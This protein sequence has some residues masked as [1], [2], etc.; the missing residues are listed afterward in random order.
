MDASRVAVLIPGL[1]Y[2]AQGPLLAYAR[3]AVERRDA[4]ARVIDWSP[5]D[6]KDPVEQVVWVSE[7]VS[8]VL[9]ADRAVLI[10]KSLGSLAAGLAARHALPA[11]WLTPLLYRPDVVETIAAAAHPPLLVGGTR[12]RGW[13]GAVAR[14]LSPCVLE[15]PDA[16]HLLYVPGPVRRTADV[17]GQVAE[18]IEDYL[19][20]YAWPR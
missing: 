14:R 11:V 1:G 16:D 12:D 6:L 20:S 19:D 15:V 13:D 17:A 2:T 4:E 5:P 3:L 10:G 8:A 9:G 18:A 7:Q